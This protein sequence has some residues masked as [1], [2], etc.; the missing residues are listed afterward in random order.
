MV[1]YIIDNEITNDAHITPEFLK[2]CRVNL[3]PVQLIDLKNKSESNTRF[4]RKNVGA[5]G[6][7]NEEILYYNRFTEIIYPDGSKSSSCILSDVVLA[8]RMGE[9]IGK[10]CVY[11]GIPKATADGLA[12]KLKATS[13]SLNP[14]FEEKGLMSDNKYWWVRYIPPLPKENAEYIRYVTE[15]EI[16]YYPSFENLFEEF[17]WSNIVCHVNCSIRLSTGAPVSQGPPKETS[18]WRAK[19]N[20]NMVS[21]Y[22]IAP[23]DLVLP[24]TSRVQ[25][26]AIGSRD[27]ASDR[28]RARRA[29]V[30]Q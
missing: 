7:P 28:L 6:E 3:G 18:E 13:P 30:S 27:V 9:Y 8:S 1:Q 23:D 2:G 4:Q 22:D 29:P 17:K 16:T 12:A 15:D 10:P 21:V 24:S 25:R 26:S 20:I 19:L 5:N 11:L 14:I